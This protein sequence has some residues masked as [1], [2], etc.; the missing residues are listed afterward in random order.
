MTDTRKRAPGMSPGERRKMIVDAALPLIAEHGAA[1]T[2]ASIARAAGIGEATVFRAFADKDELVRACLARAFSPEHVLA[3]IAAIPLDQPL[4]DRLAEAADCMRAYLE[5]MG[6]LIG[7][8]QATGGGPRPEPGERDGAGREESVRRT[9]EA[10]AG[11]F[12]PEREQLRLP[13]EQLAELFTRLSFARPLPSGVSGPDI[14]TV[15]D[16][17]LNGARK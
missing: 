3:E 11:L 5:R 10:L 13:P 6:V 12:E 14:A 4:A 17:F 16:V 7:A 1:V 15:V 2:T 9:I 8:L